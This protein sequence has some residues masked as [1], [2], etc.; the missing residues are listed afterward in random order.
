MAEESESGF[1]ARYNPGQEAIR[2]AAAQK[3]PEVG[4]EPMLWGL[5]SLGGF[6]TAF[7]LPATIVLLSFAVPLGL[8]SPSSINYAWLRNGL[9]MSN[10]YQG[11]LFRGFFFLLIAGSF[12][13]GAHR[14]T[15]MLI[16]AG[17]RKYEKGI[18]VLLHG[19]AVLGSLVALYYAVA[20]W[21]L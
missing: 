4:L 9:D 21:I 2:V 18:S 6:L 17:A 14:L 1:N 15:Y 19:L 20:G 12:L 3:E 5:F 13:H 16:E 11:L 10:P 7:L 8:S